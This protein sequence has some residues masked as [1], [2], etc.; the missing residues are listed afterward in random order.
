MPPRLQACDV[1][2]FHRAE[3]D[4]RLLQ[5]SIH[6]LTRNGCSS[7][8]KTGSLLFSPASSG[9]ICLL[10][11]AAAVLMGHDTNLRSGMCGLALWRI[12]TADLRFPSLVTP[13]FSR[14][15]VKHR[16]Q[17]WKS[18]LFPSGVAAVRPADALNLV[19]GTRMCDGLGKAFPFSSLSP[20]GSACHLSVV[21]LC[22]RRALWILRT[23]SGPARR[24]SDVVSSP[25]SPCAPAQP[26]RPLSPA[27]KSISRTLRQ[28]SSPNLDPFANPRRATMPGWRSAS[29]SV[30]LIALLCCAAPQTLRF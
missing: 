11:D 17:N 8:E 5:T 28:S 22:S 6:S 15:F 14:S 9:A 12:Y 4:R 23:A 20:L 19:L 29:E 3:L 21:S 7:V 13:Q 10:P 27:Q 2:H 1:K 30:A 24:L 25:W 16:L 18:F 26:V